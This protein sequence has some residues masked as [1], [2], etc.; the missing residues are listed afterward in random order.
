MKQVY[1]YQE[2]DTLIDQGKRVTCT[3]YPVVRATCVKKYRVCT[4]LPTLIHSVYLYRL[5]RP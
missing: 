5:I 4:V 1:N 2:I 3:C